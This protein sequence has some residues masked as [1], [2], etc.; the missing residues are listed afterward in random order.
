M[1]ILAWCHLNRD[2][3][4]GRD[5]SEREFDRLA[6]AGIDT[7]LPFVYG[8]GDC[9][10]DSSL[11]GVEKEDRL[12][13]VIEMAHTRD[14]EVH[15]V[16]LPLPRLSPIDPA[17]R[18]RRSYKSGQ[19]G[20][21]PCD[22]RPC[23]S[24]KDNRD[25]GIAILRDILDHHDVDGI[26]LDVM[27]Y[28]DTGQSLKWPCQCEACRKACVRLA[29]KETL[30]ADDLALPGLLYRYLAFREANIRE[31]T[32]R[33][34]AITKERA[35]QLS[36]AARAAYFTSALVEGQDW[37]SW[38]REGWLD[39][40]CPMNYSTDREV[41]RDRLATQMPLVGGSAPVYDGIGRKSSAGEMDPEMMIRQAEDA[42]ELGA[43]GIAIFQFTALGDEDFR[44]LRALRA[45]TN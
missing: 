42:L 15:P 33:T 11:P 2:F 38:C 6:D 5:A 17:E 27:R 39:F 10:Y 21:N 7:L 35:T 37:V 45:R 13:P 36:L 23:A 43:K 31:L 24:W 28:A 29:G 3:A 12:G 8:R 32:E 1:R 20:G 25:N 26:H 40:V 16:L 44:G 9:W 18:A 14:V 4:S 34:L 22:G 19:P 41:H 30:T